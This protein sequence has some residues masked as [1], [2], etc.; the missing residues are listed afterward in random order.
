MD[1]SYQLCVMRH[2][3]RFFRPWCKMTTFHLFKHVTFFNNNKKCRGNHTFFFC[4]RWT[5]NI[6]SEYFYAVVLIALENDISRYRFIDFSLRH[7]IASWCA[8]LAH[9]NAYNINIYYNAIRNVAAI[10]SFICFLLNLCSRGEHSALSYK[11]CHVISSRRT[12]KQ[13]NTHST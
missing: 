4:L 6:Y 1:G 13:T 3:L 11:M 10:Y 12:H 5:S 8:L 7:N 2:V 9:A